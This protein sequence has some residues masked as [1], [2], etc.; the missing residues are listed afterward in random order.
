M[1]AE[2][3]CNN[4]FSSRGSTLYVTAISQ[5]KIKDLFSTQNRQ[6]MAIKVIFLVFLNLQFS[7]KTTKKNTRSFSDHF[8]K[9][10]KIDLEVDEH[11]KTFS[12]LGSTCKF[13]G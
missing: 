4:D 9:L 5:K 12:D 7:P 8:S 2:I 1:A 11:L 13:Q 3:F 10:V 6:R